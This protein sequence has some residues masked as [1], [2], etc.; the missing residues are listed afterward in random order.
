MFGIEILK[1]V[2]TL[3]KKIFLRAPVKCFLLWGSKNSDS[4][5]LE[6]A[7][8]GK[9]KDRTLRTTPFPELFLQWKF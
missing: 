4:V 1:Y 3:R 9:I 6:N 7:G 8:F 2:S 5:V